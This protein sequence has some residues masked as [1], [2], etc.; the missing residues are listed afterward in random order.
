MPGYSTI[1]SPN[2]R[3]NWSDPTRDMLTTDPLQVIMY[4]LWQTVLSWHTGV[5]QTWNW[6]TFCDPAT[7]WPSDPVPC[8]A[9]VALSSNNNNNRRVCYICNLPGTQV[10]VLSLRYLLCCHRF[11]PKRTA[12]LNPAY[13]RTLCTPQTSRRRKLLFI[14]VHC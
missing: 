12:S 2:P 1:S 10:C 8:L 11:R 9:Y 6:V 14:N 7:Q 5:R 3:H 13:F 4:A